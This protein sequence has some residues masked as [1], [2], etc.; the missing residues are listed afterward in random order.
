VTDYAIRDD[1]MDVDRIHHWLSTDAYWAPERS[2]EAVARSVANSYCL[3]AFV[4]D[5]TQVAFARAVTDWATFAWIADVYVDREH[6]GNGLGTRIVERLRTTLEEAGIP[7]IVLATLDA[8]G[9][10]AKLGFTPLRWPERWMEIDR[11]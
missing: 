11:R 10:Y 4:P 6:R 1:G 9:V 5:G 2:R 3:G 7:R 8:H